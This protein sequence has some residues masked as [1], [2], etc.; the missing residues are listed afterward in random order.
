MYKSGLSESLYI[1]LPFCLKKCLYCDF[2]SE[3]NLSRIPAYVD[4]LIQEIQ[5]RAGGEAVN[6]IYF[7]GGTP[8]LLETSDLEKIL[9]SLRTHYHVSDKAE[10]TLEVNPGTPGRI[11]TAYF[12]GLR[13]LGIN[14]L[15]LGVQSF[16]P[17]N[18]ILLGRIHSVDQ[19]IAA[20]ESARKAGFD[21]IG[22]DLIYGLPG[23][24]RTEWIK[25]M[26]RAVSFLP[27][28][29]SCYMLTMEPNTPLYTKYLQDLFHPLSSLEQTDLFMFT[30]QYLG[31]AGYDH[32]EISNFSKGL[33][34][35]SRHNSGYWQMT[36]YSGFGPS[37]HSLEYL[38]SDGEALT[39]VRSWNKSD[40]D[41]YINDLAIG[42][43]PMEETEHISPP[44]Q[45]LELIM[46]GLRT[47]TG[48]EIRQ[49]EAVSKTKFKE[50]FHTLLKTLETEGLG[51]I[52][53]EIEFFRLTRA[54]W[55]RLDSIVEAFTEI[56]L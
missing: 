14:R 19:S 34:N 46:V 44:Q 20:I 48:I 31:E 28:H 1:H 56:I 10:I 39:P 12:Q 36:S 38:S 51:R 53:G 52:V 29:L 16:E 55:A 18:L 8:S 40:L 50:D 6:T 22:L 23:Q 30:S 41:A 15:S 45:M 27:E 42:K 37:A 5:L 7:G 21:N 33:G 26:E 24:T 2:Y 9:I 17:E 25:E 49:F 35:R 3:E 47:S 32:Y 54:G 13:Q 4:S 11:N 43:L